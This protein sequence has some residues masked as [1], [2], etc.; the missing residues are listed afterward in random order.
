MHA[1]LALVF[2]ILLVWMQA[3]A[4]VTPHVP[5]AAKICKCCS[6]GGASCCVPPASPAPPPVPLVAERIAA[7]T[8]SLPRPATV[9]QFDPTPLSSLEVF[10]HSP[11]LPRAMVQPLFRQHCAL[12]I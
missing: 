8:K 11:D 5:T 9:V 4:A 10:S 6:C 3:V 2:S 7:E 1:A 12:L